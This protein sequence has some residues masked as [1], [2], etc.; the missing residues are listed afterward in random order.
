MDKEYMS[1]KSLDSFEKWW[2]EEV[3]AYANEVQL[4][5]SYIEEEFIIDGELIRVEL[6]TYEDA[7]PPEELA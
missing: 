6:E 7:V 4:P 5:V 3:Q 2:E 1:E